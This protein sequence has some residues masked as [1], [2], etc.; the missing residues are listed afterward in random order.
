MRPQIATKYGRRQRP[1]D[2]FCEIV[3]SPRESVPRRGSDAGRERSES[4]EVSPI[5]T[6]AHERSS[7]AR[8]RSSRCRLNTLAV[9][10]R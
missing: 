10:S 1:I 2:L 4:Q 6:V 5:G 8:T 3:S 7:V 9:L